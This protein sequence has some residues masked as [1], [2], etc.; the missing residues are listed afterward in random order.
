MSRPFDDHSGLHARFLRAD[1]V[2]ALLALERQQWQADQA[3]DALSLERR[4]QAYPDL[5]IGVFCRST[6]QA[7]ASLFLLPFAEVHLKFPLKW[8][9]CAQEAGNIPAERPDAQAS[10]TQA[11]FGLSFTS[12]SPKAG[13]AVFRFFWPLAIKAGW[14]RIYLGSPLP[15]FRRALE[16][17]PGLSIQAYVLKK[18]RC[19]HAL[20]VD[21]QLR[22][23]HRRG[24]TEIVRLEENYFP[25]PPSLDYGVIL[26]G[27]IPLARFAPILRKLPIAVLEMIGRRLAI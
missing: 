2:P 3:A 15:G 19:Q 8:H 9:T 6:G 11:L 13:D 14:Q 1:D 22:Y 5:S 25:H 18:T 7:L 21:P 16:R 24:F 26:K 23:Y 20:P 27:E 10:D 12:V 4:I 17:Q